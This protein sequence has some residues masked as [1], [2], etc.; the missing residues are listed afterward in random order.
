[1]S[2]Y[3]ASLDPLFN[4]RGIAV[5]GGSPRERSLGRVIAANLR[6]GG[7]GGPINVVTPRHR[8]LDGFDTVASIG[9]LDPVPDL[10]IVTVPPDAVPGVIDKAGAAGVGAAIII[11][12]GLGQGPGSLREATANAARRH[13]IRL[14]GPNCLGVL[15]PKLGINASFA[16]SNALPGDLALLAQSGAIV[17]TVVEWANQRDI[18]FSGIVSLGDMADV[19]IGELLDYYATDPGTR[20]IL[21]YIES[22]TDPKHFM[23]ATRAAARAKP[24]IMVKAGRHEAGAKAVAS[25]TGAMAGSDAVFDAALRRAGVLRVNDMEELFAAANTLARLRPFDGRRLG[26]LTNGGGVGILTVDRL[27]DLGGEPARLSEDSCTALD[28]VLPPT[29]SRD[30]PVDIVGDADADRYVAALDVLLDANECDALLVLHVPTALTD[31]VDIA[32]AVAARIAERRRASPGLPCKPV[33]AC[34]LSHEAQARVHFDAANV[35]AYRT[36]TGAVRGF[37]HLVRYAQAQ[38]ELLAAPPSLPSAFSPDPERAR[39]AVREALARG[40]HWLDPAA[41]AEVLA[42]YDIPSPLSVIATD[43]DTAARVAAPMI[44]AHGAVALKIQSPDIPHKSD[45]GGVVLGLGSV[46]AVRAETVAMLARVTRRL[47]GARVEGVM[48]QPMVERPE[49]REL[50]AGI[51]DDAVFGPVILFGAGGITVEIEDDTALALPPLHLGLADDLIGRTRVSRLL[52]AYRNRAA[53]DRAAVALTLVKLAQLSADIPEI[54]ELDINPLLADADGVVALDARVLIAECEV[55]ADVG[56]SDTNPRFA[57]RPYPKSLEGNLTLRDGGSMR[58]RPVRPEDEQRLTRFFDA[59]NSE[60]LRQRFF[61]PVKQ[62]SRAFIARL[63]QIDYARMIVLLAVD[64]ADEVQGVGQIHTDPDGRSG[65]YA[66]LLRSVLKGHGLGWALMQHLIEHAGRSGL[67][68]ITGRVLRENTTMLAMCR[69]LGFEVVTEPED[70]SVMW[71]TLPVGT[72][73]E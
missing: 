28:A 31:P 52:G 63:T 39:R 36:L 41:V 65:E 14:V 23:S 70:M 6:A 37:T 29:W 18:G 59:V 11:T 61:A 50:I 64:D 60:D 72:A 33:L 2:I 9:A 38:A 46:E 43:A 7:F 22:I 54:R 44:E 4:P 24:V 51:A 49:A 32:K 66:I 42:A 45:V 48:V 3:R 13:G 55:C 25:H 15:I 57:I 17:A 67:Q 10:V 71:V 20:A 5:I 12:A 58:V 62:V 21:V 19:E 16:A 26:I 47:P 1:M 30:N 68:S 40:E 35:P 73:G 8:K 34:W 27:V 56:E 53:A 69:H